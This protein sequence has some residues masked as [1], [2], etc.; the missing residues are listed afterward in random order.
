MLFL[1]LYLIYSN[2]K[3]TRP[4][5]QYHLLNFYFFVCF[6]HFVTSIFIIYVIQFPQRPL[7]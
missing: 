6:I 1:F 2:Y 7:I 3:I 5:C 4:L